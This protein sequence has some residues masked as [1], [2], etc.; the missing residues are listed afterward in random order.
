MS[1]QTMGIIVGGLLPAVLFGLSGV[2]AKASTTAGIGIGPY[3]ILLGGSVVAVGACVLLFEPD[4]TVSVRSGA[5]AALSGAT[6]GLGAALVV[7]ALLRFGSAISQLAPLYNMNFMV[8][9]LI[10]L[11]VFSEWKELD[12]LRLLSGAVLIV[13]G[14]TLVSRA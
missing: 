12:L 3:L 7:L 2:F 9:V 5:H 1:S 10:G 14:G 8:A 13:I 6:Y 4:M 11:W